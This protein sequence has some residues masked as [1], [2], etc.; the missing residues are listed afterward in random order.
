[1]IRIRKPAEPPDVL[2]QAGRAAAAALC[3]RVERG[4]DR[5]LELEKA[6]Y[7]APAVREALASA[8]HGKCCFCESKI[9][10]IASG[11]VEHFRPKGACRSSADV[12]Q[13]K[14]GY[15]WLAYEWSNLNFACEQCNRRHK[16]NLFPLEDENARV[17]SHHDAARLVAERPLYINPGREDPEEHIGFR[18]EYAKPRNG[19]RRGEIAI[20][21]LGLNRVPLYSVRRDRRALLLTLLRNVRNWLSSGCPE[22]QRS[23]TV[24]NVEHVLGSMHDNAEYAAMSRALVREAIPWRV[25]SPSTPPAELLSQLE[26]DADGGRWL[27]IPPN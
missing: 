27:A 2:L 20:A 4:D 6:I 10:H 11:D 14:R 15:Y 9:K 3:E 18:R 16:R 8:Q 5:K 12:P 25:V 13:R 22:D 19:S 7:G 17:V 26:D 23:L 1:M 24:G 21:D